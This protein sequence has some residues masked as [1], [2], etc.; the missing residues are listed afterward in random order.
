M[1]CARSNACPSV[2]WCLSNTIQYNT[3][4]YNTYMDT[5]TRFPGVGCLPALGS[6]VTQPACLVTRVTNC[7]TLCIA[8]S[9]PD[10]NAQ[11]IKVTDSLCKVAYLP[12]YLP[13]LVHSLLSLS[14]SL[15]ATLHTPFAIAGFVPRL[16]S[17]R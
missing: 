7:A 14:L 13:T 17:W 8:S 12:T 5:G 2:Y 10:C 1:C 16:S 6:L 15:H 11:F 3:I 9:A 4:I